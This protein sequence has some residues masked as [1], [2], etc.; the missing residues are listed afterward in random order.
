MNDKVNIMVLGSGGREHAIVDK[1]RK[2]PLVNK[3]YAYPGNGG[4]ERDAIIPDLDFNFQNLKSF[5]KANHISVVV[6]GPEAYIVDGIADYFKDE[7]EIFIFAPEKKGAM[8]EGSKVFAKEFMKKYGIPTADFKVFD[9]PE[10][11]LEYLKKR[12]EIVVKADGLAAGK[13]VYVCDNF[14]ESKKAIEDIMIHKKFKEAG[15]KVVIEDKLKGEEASILVMVNKDK[16]AFLIPSQDHKAI[17]ENDKGPNTGG[18]GAYAPTT[19]IS[20]DLLKKIENKII[21]PLIEGLLKEG[22]NY[23]GIIYVG[24]MVVKDDIYVLEFNVRFGDPETEAI[25]PLMDNDLL[26]NI[27]LMKEGKD[28]N[29]KW[30]DGY[31]VDVVLASRGYP[32]QY[33]KGKEIFID[34]NKL[35]D[36]YI[37]HAGTKIINNKLYTNGGR[38]LNVVAIESDIKK[39][40]EKVYNAIRYINFENMYYRKDIALKEEL[41]KK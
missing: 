16:Y 1:I 20:Q 25:L 36:I 32:G 13:G 2:S 38:V 15:S 30:K 10:K 27:L 26:E 22:I 29:F 9:R 35:N 18:M 14:E 7:K 19:L 4:I 28:F 31:C 5:L 39:A 24:I 23:N 8:L 12:D 34:Y 3:L 6:V 40:R 41:R 17:Y 37:Y 21:R 11:A 33:E